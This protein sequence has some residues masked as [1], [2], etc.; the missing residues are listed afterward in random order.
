MEK[1]NINSSKEKVKH[2]FTVPEGYFDNFTDLLVARL[3]EKES[4]PVAKKIT[5]WSK[6]APW[7]Y[8]A[9]MVAGVALFFRVV[10]PS[11]NNPYANIIGLDHSLIKEALADISEDEFFEIME[12]RVCAA[13][14]YQTLL[15]DS[16]Y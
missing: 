16:N 14:Y 8:V 13:S 1:F 15:T 9:A 3:P 2:P 11:E 4:V 6:V 10:T 5:L 7:I 12:D